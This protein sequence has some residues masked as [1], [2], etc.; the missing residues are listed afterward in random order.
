MWFEEVVSNKVGAKWKFW[1]SQNLRF[2]KARADLQSAPI[3]P[4]V[5][6]AVHFVGRKGKEI[7][8]LK[9][10]LKISNFV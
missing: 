7:F 6:V 9:K 10:I 5:L 4:P 8:F 1:Q 2:A 3:S